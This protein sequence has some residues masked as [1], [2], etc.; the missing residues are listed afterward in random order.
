MRT[1]LNSLIVPSKNI[2]S[3]FMIAGFMLMMISEVSAQTA[4]KAASP[5]PFGYFSNDL[6]LW[7]FVTAVVLLIVIIVLGE[8]IKQLLHYRLK[9]NNT[10]KS[11]VLILTILGGLGISNSAEAQE[12]ANKAADVATTYAGL[13]ATAFW[14][15]T[16][17]LIL[18]LLV[19]VFL[20]N[21]I[22]SI[23]PESS[24]KPAISAVPEV[25]FIEMFNASVAV[26]KEEEI[27][28]DHEYDG[29]RE[30][31]NDLPPWW[32]YGFYLT[33]V[34]GIIYLINYH[35]LKTAPSQE[36]EYKNEMM[37]AE[38]QK[39]EFKK[40]SADN[41]DENTVTLMTDAAALAEGKTIFMN[42]CAVCHGKLGEGTVGPNLTDK[43]WLH[44]GKLNDVFKT[45]K[46]GVPSK[47]MIAW[48]GQFTPVQIQ[49]VSSYISTLAGTN[50]PNP[51]APQGDLMKDESAAM[52]SDSLATT[53]YT[54]SLTT[55]AAKDSLTKK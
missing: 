51:K 30:L 49:Q 29:I 5:S 46:Y 36:Q 19:I 10:L 1:I 25:S 27:M 28:F 43:Y 50:P 11:A 9:A 34:V 45:I 16:T 44:G 20:V 37:A 12:A 41:V 54:D 26:E 4:E 33:I 7:M 53:V 18:E 24:R 3:L 15:M 31:D 22:R 39:A 17:V 42:N 40:K 48:E 55:I 13:D 47:G 8:S 14:F 52:P 2:R 23:L 35:V 6:F 32:K 38:R 21:I